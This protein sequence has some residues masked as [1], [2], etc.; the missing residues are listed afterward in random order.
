MLGCTVV[1]VNQDIRVVETSLYTVNTK[2]KD[3][4]AFG[5]NFYKC[6]K[7]PVN[8]HC[9]ENTKNIKRIWQ[10]DLYLKVKMQKLCN[11]V[12]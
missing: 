5:I 9:R 12:Y 6:E 3:L 7:H 11:Y 10:T 1:Q 8:P 2:L 4:L